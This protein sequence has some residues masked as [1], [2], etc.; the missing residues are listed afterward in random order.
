MEGKVHCDNQREPQSTP[1][2]FKTTFSAV[3]IKL[4][5]KIKTDA[6][7]VLKNLRELG[8]IHIAHK[9]IRIGFYVS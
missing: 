7:I 3:S 4:A 8:S 1:V 2:I 9:M 6:F 5:E